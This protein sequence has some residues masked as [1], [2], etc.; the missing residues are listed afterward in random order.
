MIIHIISETSWL[1]KG[2]G[3]D[4]AFVEHV[5]L[6]EEKKDIK[7]VVNQEG[8]GDVLHS[9]TYGPYFFWKGRHY[10]GRKVFTV[11]VILI[12]S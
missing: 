8:Y 11:H 1:T 6:M 4:T 3:V 10:K 7:V 9:H 5:A 2:Q 12:L